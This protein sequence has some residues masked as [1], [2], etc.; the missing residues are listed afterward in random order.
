[1]NFLEREFLDFKEAV[2]LLKTSKP[3]L[4]RWIREGRVKCHKAG[5][6][7]RFYREDLLSFVDSSDAGREALKRELR[8][9]IQLYD[10]LLRK[11]G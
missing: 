10:S 1:V 6:E 7:W 5:R 2:E 11:D 4:Y 8:K 9:A 3:T